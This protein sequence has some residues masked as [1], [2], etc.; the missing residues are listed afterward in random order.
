[1]RDG[2]RKGERE[3]EDERLYEQLHMKLL[4]TYSRC[5]QNVYKIIHRT[6]FQSV[7]NR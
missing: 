6:C 2:R 7:I 4:C 5:K 3:G 1:M